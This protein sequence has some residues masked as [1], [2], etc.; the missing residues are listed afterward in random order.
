MPVAIECHDSYSK[1][2]TDFIS[3][4]DRNIILRLYQTEKNLIFSFRDSFTIQSFNTIC[5][6]DTFIEQDGGAE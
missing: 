3:E 4:L 1:I 5:V 6:Y 2:S